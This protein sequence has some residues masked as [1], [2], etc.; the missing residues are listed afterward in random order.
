MGELFA[1]LFVISVFT[2]GGV[3]TAY[4]RHL[5]I[6]YFKR[7]SPTKAQYAVLHDLEPIEYSYLIKGKLNYAALLGQLIMLDS[8]D[9]VEFSY[10]NYLLLVNISRT[11]SSGTLKPIDN[12]VL[13]LMTDGLSLNEVYDNAIDTLRST[14]Q[15]SLAMKG[16]ISDKRESLGQYI[17]RVMK[18]Y[19]VTIIRVFIFINIFFML[20]FYYISLDTDE[21]GVLLA[22]I[23]ISYI[24]LSYFYT[25]IKYTM[26]VS[27]F[28]K[29]ITMYSSEKYRTQYT[30]LQ[31]LFDY[32]KV[33]GSDTMNPDY[34]DTLFKQL[35][36]LYPYYVAS[37]LDRKI[38]S[39]NVLIR[40]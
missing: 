12:V 26:S 6:A 1:L 14:V 13:S 32:M 11:V 33:S 36:S 27:S 3:I 38:L 5:K 31:G 19:L 25:I 15:N 29:N 2:A 18:K 9:D 23:N 40:R 37:G 39:K 35:D 20:V 7:Q 30:E 22:A 24:A 34:D 8:G 10:S 16:W 28:K 21:T 4:K 17:K